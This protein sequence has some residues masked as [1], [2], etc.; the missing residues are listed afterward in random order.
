MKKMEQGSGQSTLVLVT[1]EREGKK[2]SPDEARSAVVPFCERD[3]LVQA[4]LQSSA[5]LPGRLRPRMGCHREMRPCFG[6]QRRWRYLRP[7]FGSSTTNSAACR[8]SKSLAGPA[9]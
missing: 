4:P 6:S 1:E 5:Y 8:T 9:S 2:W 3:S 7:T